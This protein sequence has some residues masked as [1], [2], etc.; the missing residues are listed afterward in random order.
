M[1][2]VSPAPVMQGLQP[3]RKIKEVDCS[4]TLLHTVIEGV[5]N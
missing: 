3:L 2:F 4:G 1:E 5:T